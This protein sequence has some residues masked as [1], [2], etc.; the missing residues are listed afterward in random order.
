MNQSIAVL[1]WLVGVIIF[2]NVMDKPTIEHKFLWG[3]FFGLFWTAIII[4]ITK[5]INAK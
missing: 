3:F 1:V 2:G 5:K 4:S